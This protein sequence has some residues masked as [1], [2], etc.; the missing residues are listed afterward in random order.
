MNG[1]V[2]VV[3]HPAAVDRQFRSTAELLFHQPGVQL[4]ALF[5]P[6]HGLAGTAQDLEGVPAS[7]APFPGVRVH[8]LYGDTVA[9]L[10]PTREQLDG[11]DVLV[12]DLIDIGARYYTF[13]T[14][15]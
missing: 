10:R 7:D 6:E 11:L 13:A 4:V 1:R 15:M 3:T 9:S 12:I 5:G 2:G 8:S 14:T